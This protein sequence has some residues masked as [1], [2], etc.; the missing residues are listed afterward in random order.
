[1]T[2]SETIRKS[3][4]TSAAHALILAIAAGPMAAADQAVAAGDRPVAPGEET[5]G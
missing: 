2:R 4:R 1:M 5:R 3:P